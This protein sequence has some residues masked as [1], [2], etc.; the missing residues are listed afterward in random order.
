MA[1]LVA[2]AQ[3][4]RGTLSCEAFAAAARA[5][6]DT[7][8][9]GA[10]GRVISA[11]KD[12][13]QALAAAPVLA[14][15]TLPQAAFGGRYVWTGRMR[16]SSSG[17]G[18]GARGGGAV[19]VV[20]DDACSADVFRLDVALPPSAA[21]GATA[22]RGARVRSITSVPCSAGGGGDNA[23]EGCTWLAEVAHEP[24]PVPTGTVPPPPPPPHRRHLAAAAARDADVALLRRVMEGDAAARARFRRGGSALPAVRSSGGVVMPLGRRLDDGRTVRVL[25]LYTAAAEVAVGGSAQAVSVIAAAQAT[26]D[27][28]LAGS[29]LAFRLEFWYARVGYVEAAAEDAGLTALG[30]LQGGRVRGALPWRDAYGFDLVQMMIHTTKFCGV[31]YLS[32]PGNPSFYAN[33]AFSIVDIGCMG[34]NPTIHMHEIG[35]NMGA[36]H[37][38]VT[39]QNVSPPPGWPYAWGY[40]YCGATAKFNTIMAYP[41]RN[42]A[43]RVT[44]PYYSSPALSYNGKAIGTAKADNVR[45]LRETSYV[46]A[47]YRVSAADVAGTVFD[48]GPDMLPANIVTTVCPPRAFVTAINIRSGGWVDGIVSIV[49]KDAAT[50]AATTLSI[51]A[52]GSGGTFSAAASST[53]FTGVSAGSRNGYLSQLVLTKVSGSTTK[54]FGNTGTAGSTVSCPSGAQI[55]GVRTSHSGAYVDAFGAVCSR[56]DKPVQTDMGPDKAA[57]NITTTLCPPDYIVTAVY[58]RS[59]TRLNAITSIA[60]TSL[61]SGAAVTTLSIKAGGTG[62]SSAVI[63]SAT[64][65]DGASSGIYT[66][67]GR[68]FA[69]RLYLTADSFASKAGGTYGT[70]GTTGRRASCP[71]GTKIAGLRVSSTTVSYGTYVDAFGFVCSDALS[72]AATGG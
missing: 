15:S 41:D 67:G 6:A 47:N 34:S 42:C 14:N 7:L 25:L 65:F 53:G 58:L 62:G 59:A 33:Y 50:G 48:L 24:L 51:N 30:D 64:G 2:V 23:A 70:E 4:Q 31:G 12:H 71:P 37:D 10:L 60:C 63:S 5:G 38:R 21:D 29:G 43:G 22:T 32:Y 20:W 9:F 68:S 56:T 19:T 35:H 28:V 39:D 52:G 57:A 40:R 55:V 72:T 1:R 8:A 46:I 26:A 27:A 69:S 18:G 61:S 66:V 45:L 3:A 54:V 17:S 13:F 36:Y 11:Q 16:G 49:C 44:I